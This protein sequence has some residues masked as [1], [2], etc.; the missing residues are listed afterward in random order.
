MRSIT[1]ERLRGQRQLP[2]AEL[3][4]TAVAET[5]AG[6]EFRSCV[7]TQRQRRA[8]AVQLQQPAQPFV[9]ERFHVAPPAAGR[10]LYRQLIQFFGLG[11]G[12]SRVHRSSRDF[13]F[14]GLHFLGHLLGRWNRAEDV[15]R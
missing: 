12:S 11:S 3:Q 13:V 8:A 10:L 7:S 1:A 2:A 9:R 6:Q 4:R 5:F 15:V 14:D